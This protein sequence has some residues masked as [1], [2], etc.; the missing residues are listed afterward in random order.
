MQ[1]TQRLRSHC[2]GLVAAAVV[3]AGAGGTVVGARKPA[4]GDDDAGG[5]EV[6]EDAQE[7]EASVDTLIQRKIF[8]G[9]S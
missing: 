5:K 7:M 4:V 9:Q 1:P 8:V 6:A 3:D 2:G